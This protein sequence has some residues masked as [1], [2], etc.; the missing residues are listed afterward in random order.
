MT[1]HTQLFAANLAIPVLMKLWGN[2]LQYILAVNTASTNS[3]LDFELMDKDYTTPDGEKFCEKSQL[4]DVDGSKWNLGAIE[5]YPPG[6]S[7]TVL[8]LMGPGNATRRIGLTEIVGWKVSVYNC[9]I[10]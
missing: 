3:Y 10:D 8:T 6:S 5:N 7:G 1:L 4:Q 2:I 9:V